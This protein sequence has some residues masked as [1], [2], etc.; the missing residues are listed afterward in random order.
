MEGNGRRSGPTALQKEKAPP[1]KAD[2][3]GSAREPRG[4]ERGQDKFARLSQRTRNRQARQPHK[5]GAAESRRLL[6]R[7]RCRA[8]K[9]PPMRAGRRS[10]FA[11]WEGRDDLW[12]CFSGKAPAAHPFASRGSTSLE[13]WREWSALSG[14]ARNKKPGPRRMANPARCA[15]TKLAAGRQLSKVHATARAASREDE[16]GPV[17]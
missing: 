11:P 7:R 14:P 8:K 5:K 3:T 6:A 10:Q 4:G 2:W 17:A 1:R 15:S 9:T 16:L 13:G 12:R